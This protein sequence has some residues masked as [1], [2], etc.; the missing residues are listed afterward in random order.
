MDELVGNNKHDNSAY[1]FAKYNSIYLVY[2]PEGGKR[3]LD[4]TLAKGGFTM[5]WFNPRSGE[6]QPAGF[7]INGGKT[8]DL[9][10][11]GSKNDWL[12]VIKRKRL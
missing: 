8:V 4:L 7:A 2:L 9:E 3:T 6:S 12:A 1:C 11:P 5:T 10:A